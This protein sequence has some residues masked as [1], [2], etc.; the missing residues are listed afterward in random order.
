MTR[1]S[2]RQLQQSRS[3]VLSSGV[4][5]NGGPIPGDTTGR[6]VSAPI[7]TEACGIPIVCTD[8][9]TNTETLS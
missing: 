4:P 3:V 7:P 1:R 8:S 6:A 2:R 9:L 5:Q